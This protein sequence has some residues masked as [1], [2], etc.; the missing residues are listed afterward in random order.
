MPNNNNNVS[1]LCVYLQTNPHVETI[2][3]SLRVLHKH[4]APL[5]CTLAN[6]CTLPSSIIHSFILCRNHRNRASQ[7]LQHAERNPKIL[8]HGLKY[9]KELCVE[10]S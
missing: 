2:D 10:G 6:Q 3:I 9:I 7:Q 1:T 4:T 8:P 5:Q